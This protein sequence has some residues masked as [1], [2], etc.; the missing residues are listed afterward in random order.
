MADG[1]PTWEEVARDHGRFL[2]NV[3]YRLA[4]NDSDA[5]DLVQEALLRV[6][7]GLERYQPGSLEG[8]LAR[9]VT[10][11]F[12]DEV[13]RRRRRPADALPEDPDW[14]L[15]PAP[16]ADQVFTGLSDDVQAALAS[17]PDEFRS[18]RRP[19]RCRRPAV[20]G[21]RRVARC[22][23]RHRSITDPSRPPAAPQRAPEHGRDG[24]N[25]RPAPD[26]RLSAY[27]DGELDAAERADVDGYLAESPEWRAERDAVAYAR[28]ALRG[29]SV[30]EAPPGFWEGVLS[31]ELTRAR[32]RRRSRLP[33]LV[34]AATA[35]V[36]VA[37]VV[38]AS[39]VIPSPDSVTP[40]VPR[41]PTRTPCARPSPTSPS[42]SWRLSA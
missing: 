42:A 29:L 20:R 24:V 11:V 4:G 35:G 10:N 30:H 1:V 33:R 21:D 12:L 22:P 31:P 2:Y 32:A 15:P 36:A 7:K 3:A 27:L 17:L 6:R 39:L 25:A 40:R 18:R 23:G 16:A 8:W 38:I 41:C 37:A 19:L 34:A 5:Q 9:I 28:D 13:R 26:D 14:V